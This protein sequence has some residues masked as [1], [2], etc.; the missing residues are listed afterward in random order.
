MSASRNP[1]AP[2]S[3]DSTRTCASTALRYTRLLLQRPVIEGTN[4][5][6]VNERASDTGIYLETRETPSQQPLHAIPTGSPLLR[7]GGFAA[8]KGADARLLA[9]MSDLGLHHE[10]AKVDTV[11]GCGRYPIT[12]EN[13]PAPELAHGEFRRFAT[14]GPG[15]KW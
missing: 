2:I 7:Y 12:C 15:K 3:D 6:K 8:K 13:V 14:A 11:R 10:F 4:G 1:F 9:G 5:E